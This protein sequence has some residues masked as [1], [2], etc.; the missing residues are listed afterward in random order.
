M[1][2]TATVRKGTYKRDGYR[3]VS[4][5]ATSPLTFQHRRAVGMG[6]TIHR[7]VIVDG[8]TS[9]AFCNEAYEHGLQTVALLRGWKVK[10]W[11]K[12]PGRVPVWFPLERSWSVLLPDGSRVP[13]TEVAAKR[14]MADVYGEQWELELAA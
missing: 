12:D 1:E 11:V 7:P 4:C 3:C 9:C 2:P 8:L 13:T 10:K 14:M 6:G 5:G